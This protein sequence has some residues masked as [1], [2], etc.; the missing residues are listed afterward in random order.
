MKR[1][2][3]IQHPACEVPEKIHGVVL[4]TQI[5]EDEAG[6]ILEA[7]IFVEG[8]LK[9]RYF[10]KPGKRWN[11]WQDGAWNT[12]ILDNVLRQAQGKQVTIGAGYGSFEKYSWASEQDRERM[13]EVL[14]RHVYMLDTYE[15]E[16]R[17]TEG[18]RRY[19]RRVDKIDNL[20]SQISPVT[21]DMETWVMDVVFPGHYLLAKD[22]TAHC[23]ACKADLEKTKKMKHGK[24]MTCP[25]CGADLKVEKRDETRFSWKTVVILQKDVIDGEEKWIERQ[26]RA[27]CWWTSNGKTIYMPEYIRAVVDKG[28]RYGDLYYGDRNNADEYEQDWWDANSR[29][30]VFSKALLYPGNLKEVLKLTPVE[31][32]GLDILAEK[33][34]EFKVNHSIIYQK[35]VTEYFI[36]AGFYRMAVESISDFWRMQSIINQEGKNMK[37]VLKIDGN[38]CSR[39]KKLNGGS[40]M[41]E[42]LQYEES[43]GIRIPDETLK[44]LEAKKADLDE[45]KPIL[46][47]LKSPARMANYLKKNGQ[48]AK[49]V[50]QLWRD[51]ISM[52][53][54]EGLDVTDDIVRLPKNLKQRHDELVER[55]NARKDEDRLKREEKKYHSLNENIKKRLQGMRDYF[56][57]DDEYMIIPAGTCQELMAEGR[58][59]HHCVG[60]SD[61]YMNKMAEGTSWILFMRKKETLETPYYTIEVRLRDNEILQYYSAYD[62]KPD[63]EVVDEVL[64]RYKKQIGRKAA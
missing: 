42:W 8:E 20:M 12:M 57:E 38:R 33:G 51:Y 2:E 61:T 56:Y 9:A 25:E 14:G 1:R 44:W 59:L 48:S 35:P 40:H 28:D 30:R 54:E 17:Q 46:D 53:R 31:N 63:K 34:I 3:M 13:S 24:Q 58:A 45:C 36:K 29:G 50:I 16:I 55:R 6:K 32:A 39:M 64:K 43:S 7:D 10:A 22:E 47:A 19:N 18:T 62:R 41:L 49:A 26:F 4:A 11:V 60:A 23:T 15:R 27:E 52:A 37:D 5:L 21:E